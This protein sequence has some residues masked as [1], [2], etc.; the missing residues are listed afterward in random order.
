MPDAVRYLG[1]AALYALFALL[2]GYFSSAPRYR[3]LEPG[4]ALLRLSFSHP[5]KIIADCRERNAAELAKMPANMRQAQ[6][7]PRERSPVHVR[8][9]LD[10]APLYDE[11]FA[12]AGLKR[13]GAAAGYRR[14]AIGAGEHRLRVRLNDDARLA[15]FNYERSET[16]HPVAGQVV[17]IDFSADRGG[18]L[19]K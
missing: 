11:V 2:I 8:V 1:Q 7:C 15:G 10:G 3:H 18:I 13:D 4:Q 6:D 12:P 17:L 14:L 16:V 5:G 9:E 19:I